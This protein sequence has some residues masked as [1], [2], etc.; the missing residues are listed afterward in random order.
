[1]NAEVRTLRLASV[2]AALLGTMAADAHHAFSSVFDRNAPVTVTG[3]VTK[4][5][6]MNPHTWFYIDV[7][8]AQGVVESW[9]L[10]MGSPN[11]LVR[12]GWS[13]DTLQVGHVVTVVGFRARDGSPTG[14]VREVTLSTG[15]R[16]FGAQSEQR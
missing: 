5:E 15:Q 12:R 16:L 2:A 3:K 11:A 7:V 6:W 14:A 10:E 4:V 13:H 8:N 1:M 9:G